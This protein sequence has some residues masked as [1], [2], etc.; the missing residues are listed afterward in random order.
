MLKTAESWSLTSLWEKLIK[1]GARWSASAGTS[2]GS[3]TSR[4]R[5]A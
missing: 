5:G 1:I 4:P 3:A 2:L